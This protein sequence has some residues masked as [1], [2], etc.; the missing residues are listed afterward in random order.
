MQHIDYDTFKNIEAYALRHYENSKEI[1]ASRGQNLKKLFNDIIRGKVAEYNAYYQLIEKNYILNKPELEI[2]TNTACYDADLIII[3]KDKEVYDN[4]K[5]VHVKSVSKDSYEKYG[6][7]FLIEKNDPIVSR[8]DEHEHH[9]YCVLVERSFLVYDFLHWI[10][11]RE[12]KYS[13]PKMNLP[14]KYAVYF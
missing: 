2:K 9:Y 12:V 14:T 3:G 7:S 1:Y 5:H 8:P 11:V 10:D 4:A 6:A 13:A